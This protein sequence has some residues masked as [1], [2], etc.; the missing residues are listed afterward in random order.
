MNPAEIP[1]V[2]LHCHLEGCFRPET[3]FEIA[4]DLGLDAPNSIE[5]FKQNWLITKP[6]PNLELALNR[7]GHIQKLWASEEIIERFTTEACEY[8]VEQ[9][10]RI[11]ELR[12]APN[13]IRGEQDKLT[14]ERIHRAVLRGLQNA[15]HPEITVGLIGI[16]QK[17]LTDKQAKYTADFIIE[18]SDTFVAIDFA[19]QDGGDYFDRFCAITERARTAGLGVT[20]HAG[21]EPGPGAARQVQAAVTQ[22]GATRIGHGIHIVDDPATMKFVRDRQ[23]LLEV[24]PTSNWLTSSVGSTAQHP[25]RKLMDAGIS[26]SINSDDPGVFDID[27][28]H[29]YQILM[30][31]H[32]FTGDDFDRCNGVAAEHSFLS[33]SDIAKVWASPTREHS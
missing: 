3:A 11:L 6:L 13:F 32:S 16:I 19:D 27:L 9:G 14:F 8:A 31:E 1:K 4:H 29:E 28:C 18:N 30:E 20:V 33:A 17:T 21:E 23:V 22:L 5:S 24:C 2:E 15:D 26:V 12:Y 10:I 7:F 25:I